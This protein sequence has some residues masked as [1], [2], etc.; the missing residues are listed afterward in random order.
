MLLLLK[1]DIAINGD[2]AWLLN[3]YGL[4]LLINTGDKAGA[5]RAFT[6]A[7]TAYQKLTVADWQ[8]AYSENDSSYWNRNFELFGETIDYNLSLAIQS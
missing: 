7:Q 2:H 1:E 6:Q 5:V 8:K 3:I 4:A